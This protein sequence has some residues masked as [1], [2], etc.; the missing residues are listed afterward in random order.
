MGAGGQEDVVGIE[1]G[2]AVRR[3][4]GD[5][6]GLLV[7]DGVAG[8]EVLD[9]GG[10][11]GGDDGDVGR[12]DPGQG[13]D[14]APV[15]HPHLDDGVFGIADD[16][17]EGERDADV[18]VQVALGGDGAEFL[19]Q[20]RGDH[21]LGAGLPAAA[22]DGDDPGHVGTAVGGAEFL[23]RDEG[24]GDGDE[25]EILR[26]R[27]LGQPRDHCRDGSGGGRLRDEAVAVEPFPAQGEEA[28]AGLEGAAIGVEAADGNRA[29]TLGEGAV[30]PADDFVEGEGFHGVS[31]V[32]FRRGLPRRR[33]GR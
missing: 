19:A 7:G 11:G 8:A 27:L 29:V 24:I 16:L 26:Q 17:E 2:D 23:Q 21:L 5:Q 18:V 3:E 14:L 30:H 13:G 6:V 31:S 20:H 25:A 32:P 1:D 12:G 4:R 33:R 22:G 28:I 10:A 15:V 9:V